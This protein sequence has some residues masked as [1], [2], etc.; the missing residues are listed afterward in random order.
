MGT[1][2]GRLREE[3]FQKQVQFYFQIL[4]ESCLVIRLCNIL[5]LY[6]TKFTFYYF[7][8]DDFIYSAICPV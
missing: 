2:V 4:S 8:S 5:T 6:L 7:L 3:L 1:S